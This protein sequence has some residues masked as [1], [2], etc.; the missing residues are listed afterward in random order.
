[1]VSTLIV[2]TDSY[3]R[4]AT[5]K[6]YMNLPR[7]LVINTNH[8]IINT[9][10][11]MEFS[12]CDS[13]ANATE[14][15]VI[16]FARNASIDI[17]PQCSRAIGSATGHPAVTLTARGTTIRPTKWHLFYISS[18]VYLIATVTKYALFNDLIVN[19][20]CVRACIFLFFSGD[21]FRLIGIIWFGNNIVYRFARAH[22]IKLNVF[23]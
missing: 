7:N 6:L 3:A 2:T 9:Y 21:I 16:R 5:F 19:S 8:T 17:G 4:R 1:M 13:C 11:H 12:K 22:A 23:W 14:N 20:L 18:F 10:L 15:N